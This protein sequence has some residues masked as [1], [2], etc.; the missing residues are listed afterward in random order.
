M[1]NASVK[2]KY[3]PAPIEKIAVDL[4]VKNKEGTLNDLVVNAQPISFEF[5]G[6][7]FV[8]KADLSNFDNIVYDITSKGKLDLGRIYRVFAY[9]GWNVK[10]VIEADI[11]LKGNQAD[12]AAGRF[13]RLNNSGS[14]KVNEVI[15]HSDL[16]PLP[17]I[18]DRGVF[19][20]QQDQLRFEDLRT[21]YGKSTVTLN[22][23]V[24]NVF[25]YISE[26]GPLKGDLRLSSDHLFLNELMAYNA[27]STSA[28]PDSMT[29]TSSGV[30][31]VPGNLDMRFAADVKNV[32]YNKLQVKDVK[33]EV[34]IKDAAL[35]MNKTGFTVADAATTMDAT[36]RSLSPARAFFTYHVEMNDF[37]VKK[38]YDQVE[39]FRELA[40]AAEKAQGIISLNYD[41]EGKLDGDM[42]PIMPSLK[43]GGVLSVKQVKMKG[44]KLFSGM[45]KETGKSEI[46][47]PDLSKINFK[48]S[49]KNNVVTLE[50]TK[51]KVGGFRLRI[52]GQTNFDGM[53]KFKCRLGLPP[54]GIVGIPMNITGPGQN[55][56]IKV[57]K[58]D[59]LPL[60]ERKEETDDTGN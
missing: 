22:G 15:I 18:V 54:F 41:L 2:T 20:F 57:G 32:D 19:R 14:L 12:A 40:P 43:G 59:E 36:Y 49:I 47:D 60:E 16:Y 31:M 26:S 50:K 28:R 53:V 25:N 55:P 48:T 1:E 23:T 42:Y 6:S 29:S 52:Q 17:F 46:N 5:E 13:S 58:T 56:R 35:Q 51:M 45:S 30:I 27:D 44:F 7:P 34:I 24:S 21:T 37:D 10:G 33:G 8:V 38:M 11:S 4:T 9:D 3:Y 39:L